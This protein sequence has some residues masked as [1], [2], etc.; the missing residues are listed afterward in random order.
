MDLNKYTKKQLVELV[1]TLEKTDCKSPIKLHYKLKDEDINKALKLRS[2]CLEL[3]YANIGFNM[4]NSNIKRGTLNFNIV[5]YS[6][7]GSEYSDLP[8]ELIVTTQREEIDNIY[9]DFRDIYNFVDDKIKYISTQK[10][11]CNLQMKERIY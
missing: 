3:K 1:K 11:V 10:H 5:E 7:G 9:Y 6:F 2:I 4:F 8:S